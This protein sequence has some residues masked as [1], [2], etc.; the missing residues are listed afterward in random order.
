MSPTFIEKQLPGDE[1]ILDI[2]SRLDKVEWSIEYGIISL[3]ALAV[4]IGGKVTAAG[5]T[6]AQTQ[7]YKL[8]QKDLPGY[9][10]ME[11]K[12]DYADVDDVHFMFYKCKCTSFEYTLEGE[13]YA[14]IS[15]SGNAIPTRNNGDVLDIVFNET[16]Q[17]IGSI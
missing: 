17:E 13:E 10:K 4:F 12:T 2:Y 15:A 6:P 14:T 16:A 7:T 3:D 1:S 5:E 11:A 8:N 9:F